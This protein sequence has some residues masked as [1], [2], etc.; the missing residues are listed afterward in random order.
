MIRDR[1][2]EL[3]NETG[4][5]E[6]ISKYGKAFI[7]GSYRMDMM[8][9][10]DIDLYIEDSVKVRENW[11]C[12]VKDVISVLK[13]YR[14]DGAYKENK[15][16]LGCETDLTGERWNVD[17][18]VRDRAHIEKSMEYCDSIVQRTEQYPELRKSVIDIKKKLI[19]LRMYGLDKMA[20]RHYHSDEIYRAVFEEGVRIPEEFL[21]KYPK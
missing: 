3:L 7:T 14:F 21:D 9:W 15:I 8:C 20:E 17:I 5:L 19:E 13:P 11:F 6:C 16:F 2:E 10:N 1:A 18:W 12:L 4:L